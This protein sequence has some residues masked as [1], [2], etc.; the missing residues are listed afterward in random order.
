[1]VGGDLNVWPGVQSEK[2]LKASGL[3]YTIVRPG[4][5]KNDPPSE[6][7]NLILQ[8]EDTLRAKKTDPGTGISR[9]TVGASA[10]LLLYNRT[11]ELG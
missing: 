10:L 9:E 4:G 1:M 11:S 6:V 7:G 8:K 3:D 5:L 2:Y